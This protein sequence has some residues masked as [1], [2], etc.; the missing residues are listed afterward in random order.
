MKVNQ[1]P[2]GGQL[3]NLSDKFYEGGQF[4]PDQDQMA[5]AKRAAIK[6]VNRVSFFS[7]PRISGVVN[8]KFCI[9]ADA[10]GKRNK[11]VGATETKE[12]ADAVITILR[13][14]IEGRLGGGKINW[15]E[16]S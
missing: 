4:M 1:A 6:A 14:I 10:D 7:N 2:A 12:Q 5:G 11:F 9:V 13:E 16:E 15:N 8:G 3:H